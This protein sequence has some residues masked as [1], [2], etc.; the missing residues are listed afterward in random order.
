MPGLPGGAKGTGMQTAATRANSP[1]SAGRLVQAERYN[2]RPSQRRSR[3]HGHLRTTTT[4]A[5]TSC[6][7]KSSPI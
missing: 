7:P 1:C 2:E 4:T 3:L 6:P 5:L